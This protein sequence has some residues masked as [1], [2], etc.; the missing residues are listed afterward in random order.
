M[1]TDAF[2]EIDR[3][4]A[5]Y[6]T[7]CDYLQIAVGT[8]KNGYYTFQPED[9]ARKFSFPFTTVYHSLK[10]MEREGYLEYTD[11]PENSSRLYFLAHRDE[12][13]RIETGSKNLELLIGMLLRSYT[14]LFNDY[15]KIDEVL[16]A[17]RLNMTSDELYQNLKF[18][19][20]Q[21]IIHYIP[22]REAPVIQFLTERIDHTRIRIS[23]ENYRDR[24]VNYQNRVDAVIDYA[25]TED[26]CRSVQ[27]LS[28]FGEQGSKPCGQC[29]VCKGEHQSGISNFEFKII[30]E[31]IRLLLAAKPM[32]IK[33]MITQCEGNEKSIMKVARWLLD[34]GTI[35]IN[36][37]N[38]LIFKK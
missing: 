35:E 13:Y 8:G 9:F 20:Q 32:E 23:H 16:L 27:L 4:R 31:N 37:S 14:G 5:I 36:P 11:D 6:Q 3:I 24:K 21:K 38:M 7:L 1:V 26:R 19:S 2:P 29:D 12:L 28:Y 10:L 22:K 33:E 15:V 34:Q 30:S 25:R 18:L 17:R